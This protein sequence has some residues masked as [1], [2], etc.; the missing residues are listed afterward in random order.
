VSPVALLVVYIAVALGSLGALAWLV[1]RL[2]ATAYR[3]AVIAAS[4][5]L[6]VVAAVA[7]VLAN[8]IWIQHTWD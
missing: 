5:A 3:R 8:I 7:T 2:D 4:V 1:D 6:G